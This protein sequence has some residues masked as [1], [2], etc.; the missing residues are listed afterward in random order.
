MHR[1]RTHA[2]NTILE[3]IS[4][5][6]NEKEVT[7]SFKVE[8]KK[9]A[10]FK[11]L[12]PASVSRIVSLLFLTKKWLN[13]NETKILV[14]DAANMHFYCM[15]YDFTH[16]TNLFNLWKDEGLNDWH[17]ILKANQVTC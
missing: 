16:Q 6:A 7:S 4:D 15:K 14:W 3:N 17:I 10:D 11:D 1:W 13:V 8:V 5:S 12:K 2:G 9:K